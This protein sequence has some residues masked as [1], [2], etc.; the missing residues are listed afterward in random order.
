MNE[1]MKQLSPEV[2]DKYYNMGRDLGTSTSQV[3]DVPLI[4]ELTNAHRMINGIPVATEFYVYDSPFAACAAVP[5]LKPSNAFFGSMDSGWLIAALCAKNEAGYTETPQVEALIELCKH[6]G[7]FWMSSDTTIITY[8]P[9]DIHLI[10]VD[11]TA[12]I[13][14]KWDDLAIKY[15]DGRGAAAFNGVRIPTHLHWLLKDP[16]EWDVKEVKAIIDSSIKQQIQLK[17]KAFGVKLKGL[18]K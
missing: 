1:L 5:S 16:N 8:R 11:E 15:R 2:I 10:K 7:W 13:L 12:D 17:L 4:T 6:V 9:T 3:L 18:P 14:H